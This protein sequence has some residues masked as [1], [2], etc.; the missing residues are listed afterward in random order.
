MPH[1]DK[2]VVSKQNLFRKKLIGEKTF[3]YADTGERVG[4]RQ[5]PKTWEILRRLRISLNLLGR[6]EIAEMWGKAEYHRGTFAGKEGVCRIIDGQ[7]EGEKI[8]KVKWNF[9]I[10]R[11]YNRQG[12]PVII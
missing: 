10:T 3:Y 11:H 4:G 2:K 5:L 12:E 1:G 8:L 9:G 6:K 7:K